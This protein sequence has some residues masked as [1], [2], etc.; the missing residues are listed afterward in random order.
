VV[1]AG[2][3]LLAPPASFWRRAA[4][5]A[6]DWTLGAVLVG[7][8]AAI[9][10]AW[11]D[12][13]AVGLAF[14]AGLWLVVPLLLALL[15]AAGGTPG[16]R[17]AGLRVVRARD[18][19]PAGLGTALRRELLGR[20]ALVTPLVA[21]GGAGLLGYLW[22]PRDRLG[23]TWHDHVGRTTVLDVRHRPVLA[24]GPA[25]PA[26]GRRPAPAPAGLTYA[27]WWPR[28][29]AWLIDF[30]L[31]ATVVL[32]LAGAI[33]V[34]LGVGTDVA[35]DEEWRGVVVFLA[36]LLLLTLGIAFY[37]A[38]AIG[39]CETTVGK[40]AVG[41]VVRAED[42]S[43]AGF[44]RAL[45]RE[46]LGRVVVEGIALAFAGPL[47]P[48]ASGLAAAADRRRQSWHDKIGQTIV[49]EGRGERRPRRRRARAAEP[50]DPFLAGAA[51]AAPP[52]PDGR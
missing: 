44:G 40:H 8:G 28:F 4:A 41:L 16:R 51:A 24:H 39:W 5:F 23:Q 32:S 12:D 15:T 48:A 29:G 14:L 7:I 36:T 43:R 38:L 37:N 49:V 52:G 42:G 50:H 34:A 20:A 1:P 45:N 26:H 30:S 10:S 31:V 21:A 25:G 9:L 35:E 46:L 17:V 33:A 22:A 27:G 47:A 13:D 6:I 18:G 11:L 2:S 19:E 3:V